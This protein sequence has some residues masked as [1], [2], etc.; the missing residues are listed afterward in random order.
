[1]EVDF[2]GNRVSF[3]LVTVQFK[4]ESG[5]FYCVNMKG[6]IIDLKNCLSGV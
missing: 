4:N 2:D 1:M 6:Q 3:N 5:S